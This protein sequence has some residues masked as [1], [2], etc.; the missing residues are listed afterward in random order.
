[1]QDIEISLPSH[2]KNDTVAQAID[3]ALVESG[4]HIIMRD[5]LKKYPNCIHWHAKNGNKP[6]T[7]EVTFWPQESRA[8]FTVQSGRN[9]PWI[10]E[11]LA[12]VATNF[13]FLRRLN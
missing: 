5:T 11:K 7:L 12:L 13:Q 2:Y 10:E 9:A 3:T 4:L 6:G 8:W 1:M